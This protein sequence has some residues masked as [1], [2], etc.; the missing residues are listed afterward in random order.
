MAKELDVEEKEACR[1][2]ADNHPQCTIGDVINNVFGE[3]DNILERAVI[4]LMVSRFFLQEIE[5]RE[6]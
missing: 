1:Q 2:Y 5:E 6:M 4:T 3:I